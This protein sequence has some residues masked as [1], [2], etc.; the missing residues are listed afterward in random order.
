MQWRDR[1]QLQ[2][3]VIRFLIPLLLHSS[4]CPPACRQSLCAAF[5][6]VAALLPE[7]APV[8]ELLV[9]LNAVSK[10]EVRLSFGRATC[11]AVLLVKGACM[12]LSVR[13]PACIC[14]LVH[15]R[16]STASIPPLPQIDELDY[17][18]RMD[19]YTRLTP[20][21]WQPLSLR[22]AAPL[23]HHCLHDLRNAGGSLAWPA[24]C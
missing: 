2:C 18:H 21:T 1:K 20:A 11:T 8:A 16:L 13:L 23:V 14:Q 6:A 15:A 4:P 22:Q 10:T 17:G 9:Q 24:C 5:T 7:L 19:A 3:A 12:H